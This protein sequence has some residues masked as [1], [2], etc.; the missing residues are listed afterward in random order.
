MRNSASN[1]RQL[2]RDIDN[3][4]TEHSQR[5]LELRLAETLVVGL[6]CII[7]RTLLMIAR[8]LAKPR[9]IYITTNRTPR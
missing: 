5:H 3:Y 6:L 7:A 2:H 1:R 8:T 9:P 4:M